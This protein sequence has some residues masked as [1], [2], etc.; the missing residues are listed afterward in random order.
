VSIDTAA[1][2]W[3]GLDLVVAN[4]AIELP[5]EDA[6]VDRLALDAWNRIVTTNL[7]GQFLTCKHGARHLLASGGGAIVCLGSNCGSLGMALASPRTARPKA[8]S[9]P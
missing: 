8:A 5:Q 3:G 2:S 9:S 6:R 7:N 1:R 4:A